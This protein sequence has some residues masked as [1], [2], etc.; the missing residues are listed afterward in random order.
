MITGLERWNNARK[1]K[2]F[3]N[4]LKENSDGQVHYKELQYIEDY[5]AVYIK[6]R[7]IHE[8][9]KYDNIERTVELI[10]YEM[11]KMRCDIKLS[12]FKGL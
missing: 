7:T 11:V 4:N 8:I 1:V 3:L 9:R 2:R 5:F 12:Y 6:S 10:M